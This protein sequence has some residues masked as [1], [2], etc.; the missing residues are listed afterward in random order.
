MTEEY[1]EPIPIE[2]TEVRSCLNA[3]FEGSHLRNRF[4]GSS[5]IDAY[6]IMK[7]LM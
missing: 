1:A 2:A 4:T 3:S 7:M 5:D 6:C